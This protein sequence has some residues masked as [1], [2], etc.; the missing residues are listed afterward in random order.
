[1]LEGA[2]TGGNDGKRVAVL[3]DGDNFPAGLADRL[4][5]AIAP[6]GNSIVRRVYGGSGAMANWRDKAGQHLVTLCEV[7]PGKN[8]A[9]MRLAMEA[10]DLL[11]DGEAEAFCIVSSDG[12]FAEVARRLRKGGV[13]VHGYGG[14]KA[15][16]GFRRACDTFVALGK[17]TSMQAI[18]PKTPPAMKPLRELFDRAIARLEPNTAQITL[19]VLGHQIRLLDKDFST[20]RYGAKNLKALVFKSGLKLDGDG[21]YVITAG[22][23]NAGRRGL[24]WA[25]PHHSN[26]AVFSQAEIE[27]EHA[28]RRGYV[29]SADSDECNPSY[30]GSCV[31]CGQPLGYA[32]SNGQEGGLCD[33]CES[34]GD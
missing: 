22:S 4:F 8:A 16:D 15:A 31:H 24:G 30:G 33:T 18:A 10:V 20:K 29:D 26:R 13:T 21:K 28:R 11:R 25:L 5:A 17:L 19:G 3:I 7:A 2:V 1:L 23:A 12:D 14:S 9:D 34:Q 27:A 6:L 32:L